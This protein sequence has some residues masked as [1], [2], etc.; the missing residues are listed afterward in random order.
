MPKFRVM[1]FPVVAAEFACIEA[2][3]AEE[4]CEIAGTLWVEEKDGERQGK[5]SDCFIGGTVWNTEKEETAP[6]QL[7]WGLDEGFMLIGEEE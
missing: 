7:S 5:V 6:E 1:L 3:T 4:A 2:E